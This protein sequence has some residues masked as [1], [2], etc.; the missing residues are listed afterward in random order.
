MKFFYKWIYSFKSL[1]HHH[2]YYFHSQTNKQTTSRHIVSHSFILP[3]VVTTFPL[4]FHF[5]VYCKFLFCCFCCCTYF[6]FLL[7]F[8]FGFGMVF[9]IGFGMFCVFWCVIKHNKKRRRW[10]TRK[11]KKTKNFCFLQFI[12]EISVERQKE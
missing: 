12:H 5:V 7:R 4:S 8:S 3:T 11:K 9:C 1:C 6:C 10:C 2:D